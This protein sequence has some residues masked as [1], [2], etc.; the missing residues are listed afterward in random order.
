MISG[1]QA[2]S[3]R[4]EAKAIKE[5]WMRGAEP[6]AREVLDDRPELRGGQIRRSGP[7]L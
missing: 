7:G 3:L 2:L 4:R 1:Q 5:S 6:N